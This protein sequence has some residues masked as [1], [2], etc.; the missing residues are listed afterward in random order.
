MQDRYKQASR[1]QAKRH[2]I[3]TSK[4]SIDSQHDKE[5]EEQ[6]QLPEEVEKRH[7]KDQGKK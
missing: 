4:T 7:A 2:N 6:V 1:M 3:M 5:E